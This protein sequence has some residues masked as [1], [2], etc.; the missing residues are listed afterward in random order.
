MKAN[1]MKFSREILKDVSRSFALTIPMLDKEIKDEVLLT[2]LQDRILDNFEDE[3]YPVDLELQKNMMDKVSRIFSPEDY[4]RR[5]DFEAVKEKSNLIG[6]EALQKLNK[7]IEIIYE[8]YDNFDL[9]VKQISHKWL[10][11][12][13]NGMQKY[14][15]KK[16][17]TFAELDEYCYYVAG[18]VGGFLTELI[19]YKKK[20]KG[21][22][23]KVLEEN[24]IDAGLFLQK[25]NLIR[26]IR[27]DLEN[28]NK[29]FWPLKELGINEEKLSDSKYKDKALEALSVMLDDLKKHTAGLKKYYLA[30]PDSLSGY[31]RFF[32][33]N[34][35]LGLATLDKLNNNPEV[36]YGNKAVKV[37]KLT[38]L[39]I[40]RAPEKYFLKQI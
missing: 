7:N 12:M 40:I 14:L 32:S 29:N 18:T 24:F 9:K 4:D 37:S 19:I 34:N 20:L 26:D 13:N 35:A 31:K 25:I 36:F 15:D 5:A 22:R 38:F 1:P 11:E 17:E 6:K 23:K 2:Y 3:I 28:R 39:N 33:V 8:V 16:V 30:L 10:V 21:D 27:D